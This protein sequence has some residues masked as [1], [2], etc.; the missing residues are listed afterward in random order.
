MYEERTYQSLLEEG[1]SLIRDNILKGE[2]SFVYN[3]VSVLAFELEK[4]YR[5]LDYLRLQLDPATADFENLILMAAARGIYPEDAVAARFKMEADAKVPM[6]TRFSMS[7]LAF[8]T[9]GTTEDGKYAITCTTPGSAPNNLRGELTAIDHV[10]G[11][12]SARIVDIL[13]AGSDAT[14]REELLTRYLES[15][16]VQAFGGNRTD[17]KRHLESEDG[18]GGC[19]VFPCWNGPTTVKCVLIGSDYGALSEELVTQIQAK[20][21]PVPLKG[22]GIAPIGHDVTVES[23][24]A[25]RM[26][27][28]LTVTYADG[29]S[30][31]DAEEAVRQAIEEYLLTIRQ[32]W[33]DAESEDE[34][35]VV[36]LRRIEAAVLTVADIVD[37]TAVLNDAGENVT[38]N[39]DEIPVAGDVTEAT[40]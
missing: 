27:V 23:V 1:L 21:C 32:A 14:T 4:I 9:T 20:M 15:F 12:K 10:P 8:V 26:N 6:G 24:K 3:P 18:V 36:Y 40:E 7:G 28:K 25:V 19:R 38:L 13:V 11:L 39:G 2:G 17:Y 29:K 22:Y 5:Q 33:K 35:S 34:K 31:A 37:V 16:D 30:W